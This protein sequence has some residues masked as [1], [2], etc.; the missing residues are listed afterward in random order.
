MTIYEGK[1]FKMGGV[2]FIISGNLVQVIATNSEK[3]TVSCILNNPR[4][5]VAVN[6][7]YK[8]HINAIYGALGSRYGIPSGNIQIPQ[9]PVKQPHTYDETI[10]FLKRM[11]EQL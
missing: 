1:S 8:Q 9:E 11:V 2:T 10:D 4:T 6:P 3:S 5:N 7:N